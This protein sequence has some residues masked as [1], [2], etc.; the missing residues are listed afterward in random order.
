MTPSRD[1]DNLAT[2]KAGKLAD[3]MDHKKSITRHIV[4]LGGDSKTMEELCRTQG[5]EYM[6]ACVDNAGAWGHN[7]RKLINRLG[8][9][10]H[11]AHGIPPHIFTL[12]W[13]R[14][15]SL[16]LARVQALVATQRIAELAPVE[17]A[18]DLGA[19]L[20]AQGLYDIR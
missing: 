5:L 6:P 7:M 20:D 12:A 13:T 10:A 4:R 9:Y 11:A 14:R 16:T 3:L 18:T 8:G 19:S 1:L 2:A 17:D 15:I